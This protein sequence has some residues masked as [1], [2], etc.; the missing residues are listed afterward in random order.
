MNEGNELNLNEDRK[1]KS[2]GDNVESVVYRCLP[3]SIS[4]QG[5]EYSRN[6]CPKLFFFREMFRSLSLASRGITRSPLLT[7]PSSVDNLICLIGK[8]YINWRFFVLESNTKGQ[9]GRNSWKGP[10]QCRYGL[11]LY[12]IFSLLFST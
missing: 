9:C 6:L 2:N 10:Q 1:D 11:L 8:V 5:F 4:I 12:R 7:R 3:L